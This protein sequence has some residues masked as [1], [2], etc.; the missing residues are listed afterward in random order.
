MLVRLWFDGLWPGFSWF[1]QS[2][3]GALLWPLWSWLMSTP[4]RRSA[5]DDL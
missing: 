3:T 4:Q 1:L 5:A 2:F